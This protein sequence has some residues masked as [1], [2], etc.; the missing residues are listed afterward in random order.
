MSL[1]THNSYCP[2]RITSSTLRSIFPVTLPPSHIDTRTCHLN[3]WGRCGPTYWSEVKYQDVFYPFS[4]FH[5]HLLQPRQLPRCGP[6]QLLSMIVL[7]KHNYVLHKTKSNSYLI[8]LCNKQTWS[9]AGVPP[10]PSQVSNSH[11]IRG[12]AVLRSLTFPAGL[13]HL[14]HFLGACDMD[15]WMSKQEELLA[16]ET[17]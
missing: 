1:E 12:R 4:V 15:I 7:I 5:P 16:R 11:W 8:C 10:Q 6:T 13:R 9:L 2:K 3:L 17:L 14:A